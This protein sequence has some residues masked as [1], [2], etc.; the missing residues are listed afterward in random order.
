MRGRARKAP[1]ANR[2]VFKGFSP[3]ENQRDRN[4]EE[5][6]KTSRVGSWACGMQPKSLGT[7]AIYDFRIA[8]YERNISSVQHVKGMMAKGARMAGINIYTYRNVRFRA[9]R[10]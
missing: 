7:C 9:I 2:V 5:Q 3:P 6:K 10:G 1:R 4:Q 8:I